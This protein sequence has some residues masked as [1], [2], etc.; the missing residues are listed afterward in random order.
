[1]GG[2]HQHTKADTSRKNLRFAFILNVSFTL[3]E[4]IG[5]W[6]TNSIA[7][8][9]DAI[10][11]LGDSFAIGSALYLAKKSEKAAS[12]KFHYGYKR[13][14]LMSALINCFILLIGSVFI[15]FEAIERLRFPE[16]TNTQGMLLFALLGVLM[17]GYAAWKVHGGQTLNEKVI[18]LHLMEDVLGWA[19]ILVGAIILQFADL[20]WL[21]PALS[22]GIMII[23]LR[24]VVLRLS[25]TVH[26]FLQGVPKELQRTPIKKELES[27][28]G[29][30]RLENLRIWSLD[31]EQHVCTATVV[32][33]KEVS[34]A[35][36]LKI[37][38]KGVAYL[39]KLNCCEITLAV[40]RQ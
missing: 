14:S 16:P 26:L 24:G 22:L 11:D 2:Q 8:L 19:A 27:W 36:M 32:V 40:K 31:G 30:H 39:E 20:P 37:E 10:H 4:I 1:M 13:L 33:N 17:N 35:E 9:S 29:V 3:I 21:D 23:I 25:E 12:T 38:A 7:I 34:E 5:G 28:E 18:A 6:Y 15:L